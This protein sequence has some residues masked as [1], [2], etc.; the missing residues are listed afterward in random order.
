MKRV[1]LTLAVALFAAV[2]TGCATT[3]K[4]TDDEMIQ[5][6]IA[7]WSAGLTEKNVEKF[8]TSISED[9][10]SDQA[11]DKATLGDFIK[12]AIDSG[13]LEEG[14][15][16]LTDAQYTKEGDTCTVYP[17]DLASAAGSVSVE[18]VLTKKDGNWLIT[19]MSVD[20]L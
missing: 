7:A 9:F 20:G 10:A 19:A 6:T 14:E 13:Y 5:T 12:D 4:P 17:V 11:E 8:L 16:T 15:I 2:V 3:S 18:L 1:A